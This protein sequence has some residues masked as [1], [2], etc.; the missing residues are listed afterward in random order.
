VG[1][2]GGTTR[3]AAG[4]VVARKSATALAR[5][6]IRPAPPRRP[7]ERPHAVPFFSFFEGRFDNLAGS[8][9]AFGRL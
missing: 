5:N 1:A 4:T 3:R 7:T 8:L 6:A 2:S 9:N